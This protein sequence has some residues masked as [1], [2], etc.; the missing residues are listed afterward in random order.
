MYLVGINKV[1]KKSMNSMGKTAVE[2]VEESCDEEMTKAMVSIMPPSAWSWSNPA[3][4]E[5]LSKKRE[6][7]MV[8]MA[9]I[10]TMAFQAAVSPPGGVWQEDTS[11]HRAGEA[12]MATTHPKIYKHLIRAN[13]TAFVSSLITIFMVTV[14]QRFGKGILLNFSPYA[15]WVSLAAIAVSFGG[16]VLIVVPDTQTRSLT[17]IK[18]VVVAVSLGFL[19]IRFLRNVFITCCVI[20]F[21]YKW[22][23]DTLTRIRR[24]WSKVL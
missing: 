14:P 5:T 20:L 1:E 9:L 6:Q 16:S 13:T 22:V 7:T 2:L 12:V 3:M 8:V 17:E 10:A 4:L 23:K 11:S 24:L 18:T 21:G 19:G 15:V